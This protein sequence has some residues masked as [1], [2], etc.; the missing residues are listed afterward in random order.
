MF[1]HV[2][3]HMILECPCGTVDD[4]LHGLCNVSDED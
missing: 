4:G 2:N 3:L 1:L